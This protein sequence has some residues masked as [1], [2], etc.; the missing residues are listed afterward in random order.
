MKKVIRILAIDGGGIRG[1]IPALVLTEIEKRSGKPV[2]QLFDFVSGTST[3]SIL[4]LGL[5]KPDKD[6][7]SAYSAEDIAGLYQSHGKTVFPKIPPLLSFMIKKL[8]NL[9]LIHANYPSSFLQNIF[10]DIFND[11]KM[12]E[13][14]ID[15]LI[16]AY[17][18]ERRSAL[19]FTN[20]KAR[21]DK[22]YNLK[23]CQVAY[24]ANA[25]PTFFDPIRISI[26]DTTD[27]YT[28][29]DGGIFANNPSLCAL[30][31]A[32]KFYPDAE[33]FIVVSIGTGEPTRKYELE[34][35]K[36]WKLSIWG[37]HLLNMVGDGI[38]D[39]VNYQ[40]E[41]LLPEK[42]GQ[43][44]YYRLQ[45]LLHPNNECIDNASPENIEELKDLAY[46]LIQDNNEEINRL[47]AIL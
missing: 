3:G 11:A 19:L 41:Q 42:D 31:E 45:V 25:A 38:S 40:M 6:G 27:Y 43:K 1:I 34:R 8:Q 28:L 17:D 44:R 18:I 30:I 23:M 4:A 32:R 14:L 13:S 12:S 46:K 15:V 36:K 9:C 22:C 39:T 10:R 47:C 5:V 35:V 16:P 20:R 37:R 2:S 24:A 29:L 21:A 7:N 33:E 26:S